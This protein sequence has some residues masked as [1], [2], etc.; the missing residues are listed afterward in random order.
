MSETHET[1]SELLRYI[2]TELLNDPPQRTIAHKIGINQSTIHN[3]LLGQYPS[4]ATTLKVANALRLEPQLRARWFAASRHADPQLPDRPPLAQIRAAATQL[5]WDED[6]SALS[7]D[8][9]DLPEPYRD[10]INRIARA[11]IT[12]TRRAGSNG[13]KE[14][15]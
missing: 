8:A 4:L 6:L 15:P 5:E 13:T 12:H 3:I 7:I 1:P 9:P 10:T 11:A 2:L 14:R